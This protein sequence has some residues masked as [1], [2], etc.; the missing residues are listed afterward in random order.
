MICAVSSTHS[1][2]L[3]SHNITAFSFLQT[4]V[5]V[6]HDFLFSHFREG[7]APV[8]SRKIKGFRSHKPHPLIRHRYR[9]RPRIQRIHHILLIGDQAACDDGHVHGT[10]Q[11][12]DD[13]RHQPR[14]NLHRVGHQGGA[15][16]FD[17]SKGHGINHED[18][19]DSE[20]P[21]LLGPLDQLGLR[22]NDPVHSGML[23]DKIDG[24][25]FISQSVDRS[26]SLTYHGDV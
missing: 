23:P 2:G 14:Q 7:Q 1:N 6:F 25:L 10:A 17:I 21:Q 8:F 26:I 3:P 4:F 12:F 22:G 19:Q 24:H 16:F 13:L 15:L 11:L 5:R 18:P 9:N 20:Q